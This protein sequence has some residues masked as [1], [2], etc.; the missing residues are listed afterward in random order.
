MAA[1][2]LHRHLDDLFSRHPN[3]T[4][5]VAYG[6]LNLLLFLPLSLLGRDAQTVSTPL[7]ADGWQAALT[8][9]F[10][11]RE[12]MD[13][14]RISIELTVTA[15]LW[16]WVRRLRGRTFRILAAVVYLTALV[17]AIYAAVLLFIWLL[18]PNFYSQI[19]LARDGLP[20]LLEHLGSGWWMAVGALL[21]VAAGVA[22]VLLLLDALFTAGAAVHLRRAGRGLIAT[23]ALLCLTALFRYQFYTARPEM[24]ASSLGYKLERN[25]AASR[26]MRRDVLAFDDRVVQA[27]YA[28]APAA[29]S[30]QPNIYLIFIESYGTV[31]YK[32]DDL[33]AAYTRLLGELE[34]EL[35]AGGW[36]SASALSISPTWGG[37]SW[38]AYTSALLGV[39]IDNQPQ[40]LSLLNKYQVDTYPSLGRTL[41][42]QGYRFAWLS[43]LEDNFGEIAWQRTS[44]FY[45]I[46]TLFRSDDVDYAGPGY[47][48]GPAPPDQYTLN[49]AIDSLR[50]ESDQPLFFFT[51]TQN[52]HYPWAPLPTLAD[53]WRTLTAP[54]TG[55]AAAA[56]RVD[57]DTIEHAERRQNYLRAVTYQLQMLTRLIEEQG[58][59]N[60]LFVLVGDHQPPVVSRRSDGWETP[61]HVISRDAA[62]VG[63]FAPYGFTPGLVAESMETTLHHEGL[64]SLLMRV[65]AARDGEQT[66]ALPAWLPN[67]AEPMP[68][69][70]A[71]T[72]PLP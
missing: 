57:P 29:L 39:H 28:Y 22:L 16:V 68:E 37:G 49:K 71:A 51:I 31:L 13:P 63:A 70:Q 60:A 53:D 30:H 12:G 62:L 20:F 56:P 23:A 36:Q 59:D 14:L 8:R 41:H 50:S 19:Q 52:S 54:G 25:I 46:D 7:L 40:Y 15:A 35:A 5:W 33:R 65:L 42:N 6:A 34:S 66:A 67:G 1:T 21:A 55:A 64:Y 10:V 43:A 2:S 9:L 61:V 69:A 38:M 18:E 45:S 48:W 26:Q 72:A 24:V 27:A 4:F 3:L 17:Y 11:W 44:R 58:D 47:G 32:R